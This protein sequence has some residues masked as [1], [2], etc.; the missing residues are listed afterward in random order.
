VASSPG[1]Y[2]ITFDEPDIVVLT[3]SG[4]QNGETIR[5][6]TE[7]MAKALEGRRARFA[8]FAV[9]DIESFHPSVASGGADLLALLKRHGIEMSVATTKNGAVRMMGQTISFAAGF[10]LRFVATRSEA[11]ARLAE[12]RL[13]R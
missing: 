13:G 2:A 5:A 7:Q 11:Y 4:H 10:K 8:Y 9:D 12:A 6:A 3:L 1:S